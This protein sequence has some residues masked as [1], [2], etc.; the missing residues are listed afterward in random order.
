MF[1]FENI[2]GGGGQV[3]EIDNQYGIIS[4]KSFMGQIME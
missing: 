3:V 4:Y 1:R 2:M